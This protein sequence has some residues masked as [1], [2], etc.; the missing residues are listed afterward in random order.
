MLII[1]LLL[2][3]EGAGKWKLK[4]WAGGRVHLKVGRL[5]GLLLSRLVIGQLVDFQV[6]VIRLIYPCIG[7]AVLL[8]P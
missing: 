8:P 6:F 4:R 2:S 3:L 5:L 7:E 1:G